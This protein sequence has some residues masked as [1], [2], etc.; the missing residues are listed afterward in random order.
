MNNLWQYP[1]LTELILPFKQHIKEFSETITIVDSITA[2]KVAVKTLT[3]VITIVDSVIKFPKKVFVEAITI[4]DTT[5]KVASRTLSEVITI[6]DTVL[7]IPKKVLSETI[8]IVDSVLKKLTAGRTFTEVIT[9]VDSVLKIPKKV[10]SE[11]ITIVDTIFRIPKK[12]LSE[13]LTIID[14]VRRYLNGLL[15]SIWDKISKAI[16]SFSK[17]AKPIWTVRYEANELPDVATPAW[18]KGGDADTIEISPAGFLHVNSGTE[19]NGLRYDILTPMSDAIGATIEA[20]LKIVAGQTRDYPPD[21]D[22]SFCEIALRMDNGYVDLEIYSDGIVLYVGGQYY[23]MDTT[24]DYHVYRVTSKNGTINVYVDGILRITSTNAYGVV[25]FEGPFLI[26]EATGI[27]NMDN[28][29]DYVY[30]SVDG[31][32]EPT[33]YGII[34]KKAAKPTA[35]DIW[36]KGEKP[37]A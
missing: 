33:E 22:N 32:F 21:M 30:Y 9:I 5:Q 11:T 24:D 28:S 29:W 13:T 27:H 31:A 20:R 15:I 37:E 16:A 8:T 1:A 14:S 3:E 18:T 2:Q 6:V 10:L 4:V 35:A 25:G 19:E 23:D 36:T 34:Y 12:V 7:K 26:A 17:E